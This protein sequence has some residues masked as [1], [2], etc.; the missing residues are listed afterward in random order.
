M[1]PAIEKLYRLSGRPYRIILGLM[2]GT[3]FD[4]LDLALCRITGS[5]PGT[6]VELLHFTTVSFSQSFKED[7]KS[8]FSRRDAD[9]EKV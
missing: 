2:S 6:S 9:L 1:N 7:L 5:G 8:I 3:S 4:G